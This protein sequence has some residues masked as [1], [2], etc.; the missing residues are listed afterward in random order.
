MMEEWK[1]KMLDYQKGIHNKNE[2]ERVN[3]R[4]QTTD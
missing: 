3:K 4:R 2:S 1:D